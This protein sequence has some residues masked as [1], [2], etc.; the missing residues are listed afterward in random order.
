MADKPKLPVLFRRKFYHDEKRWELFAVFP[1]LPAQ[2]SSWYAMEAEAENGDT[3]ACH[4]DY[5]NESRHCRDWESERVAAFK[6]NIIERWGND[7]DC[8]FELVE[9]SRMTS[10]MR[11]ERRDDWRKVNPR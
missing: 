2:S 4:G 1:T 6:K 10:K 3:F 11:D 8:P 7:S 5:Y 9:Y